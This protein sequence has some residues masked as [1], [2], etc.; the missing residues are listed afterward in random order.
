M[1]SIEITDNYNT[2]GATGQKSLDMVGMYLSE[3]GRIPLLTAEDEITLGKYVKEMM[4]LLKIRESLKKQYGEAID[5]QRWANASGV[6]LERLREILVQGKKCKNRMIEANLRLVVSVVK[7][8]CKHNM[9]F[10]D[11]VQEGA[12]GLERAV[13]KYD[14]SRGYRFSTYAY[15]WIRQA[16]TRAVKEKSRTV[17]LP[18]HV[19]ETISKIQKVQHK[20]SLDL[21]RIPTLSEVSAITG[22]TA[23]QLRE[24]LLLS[25]RTVSINTLIGN[26]LDTELGEFIVDRSISPEAYTI[27]VNLRDKVNELLLEL[28]SM[29]QQVIRLRFGLDDGKQLSLAKIGKQLNISTERVRQLEKQALEKLKSAR[30]K[31]QDFA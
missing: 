21:G 22:L 19:T 9:E 4:E 1:N 26:D 23:D 16:V 17:R 8:Y 10:L 20:L 30:R 18:V 13:E 2:I 25:R 29:Q 11:L 14:P 27:S 3:I 5:D 28:S 7:K 15:W 12:F 31:I 24:Y 6:T